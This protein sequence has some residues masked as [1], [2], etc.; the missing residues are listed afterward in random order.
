VKADYFAPKILK[1]ASEG[2]SYREIGHWLGLS[3]NAVLD[4]VNRDRAA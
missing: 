1:L 4:V 3:K 2:Q